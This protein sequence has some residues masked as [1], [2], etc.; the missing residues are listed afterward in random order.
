MSNITRYRADDFPIRVTIKDA[1]GNALDITGCT[2]LL[3]VSEEADPSD[4]VEEIFSAVGTIIAPASSGV[5][6]FSPPGTSVVGVFYF[7]I[8]MTDSLGKIKTIDK[9][10]Y[11]ILQD[12]TKSDEEFEWTPNE[13]P[14]DGAPF[15]PFS[16]SESLYLLNG[17]DLTGAFT[18]ETRDT[19]RVI[20]D[21]FERTGIYD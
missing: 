13:T 15:V 14:S 21:S 12:I 20:R 5:V 18:Y 16:N 17:N 8:Q 10:Q 1:N 2:F 4:A 11:T 9:G 3:T 19:R 6:E 7:D